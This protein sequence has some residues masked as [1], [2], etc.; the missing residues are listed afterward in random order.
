MVRKG[1]R[2]GKIGRIDDAKLFALL[3]L[4]QGGRHR[5]LVHLGQQTVVELQCR[6]VVA[7]DL[8]VLL[9]D[10][11]GRLN[12]ALVG[13]N[14][15]LDARLLQLLVGHGLLRCAEL[16]FELLELQRAQAG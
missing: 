4:L 6:V 10:P 8:F 7:R 16:R 15:L 3:A 12:P 14:L 5:R 2:L 9:F 1:W 11:W 13:A